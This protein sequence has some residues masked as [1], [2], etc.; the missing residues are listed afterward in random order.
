MVSHLVGHKVFSDKQH[1]FTKDRSRLTNLLEM[2]N[3]WTQALDEGYG[4]D[5]VYLYLLKRF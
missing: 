2:F 4:L 1:E 5:V 3:E